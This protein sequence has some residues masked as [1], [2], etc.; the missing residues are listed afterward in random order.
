MPTMPIAVPLSRQSD[1]LTSRQSQLGVQL[2]A[3]MPLAIACPA[4]T[5]LIAVSDWQ[6]HLSSFDQFYHREAPYYSFGLSLEDVQATN[7][8]SNSFQSATWSGALEFQHQER[9]EEDLLSSFT[10]PSSFDITT[11][12][13][14]V[15]ASFSSPHVYT[16]GQPG[17]LSSLTQFDQLEEEGSYTMSSLPGTNMSGWAQG[18][19]NVSDRTD[20]G[21]LAH[22][23]TSPSGIRKRRASHSRIGSSTGPSA[24]LSCEGCGK[25]FASRAERE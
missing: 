5:P 2:P 3:S 8:P 13:L 19:Y 17:Y 15:P 24:G 16:H 10:A 18:A 7:T 14:S 21:S 20:F 1:R 25:V 4:S 9:T 11:Q 22:P 12:H 23:P 6:Q